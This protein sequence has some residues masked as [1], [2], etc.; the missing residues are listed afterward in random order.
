[1]GKTTLAKHLYY[2]LNS[3]IA[4]TH[5]IP[6]IITSE[7]WHRFALNTTLSLWDIWREALINANISDHRENLFEVCTKSG[8]LIPIFDG[9]DELCSLWSHQFYPLDVIK[10]LFNLIKDEDGKIL[11][12]SRDVFWEENIPSELNSQIEIFELRPFNK[13]QLT[14][15]LEMRFPNDFEARKRARNLVAEYEK[16]AYSPMDK[17]PPSDL[18]L[19]NV[20]VVIE[21]LSSCAEDSANSIVDLKRDPIYEILKMLCKRERNRHKIITNEETQINIFRDIAVEYEH[22]FRD[23][24]L[25]FWAQCNS[26]EFNSLDKL[27][28]L[29]SHPFLYRP[30]KSKNN[31]IFRYD[32]LPI[33]LRALYAAEYLFDLTKYTELNKKIFSKYPHGAQI[34]YDYLEDILTRKFENVDDL[35]Q[36]IKEFIINTSRNSQYWLDSIST[37]CFYIVIKLIT[38]F[39]ASLSKK[40]RTQY[41][42][43]C[44][45]SDSFKK[46]KFT[47][48]I[49]SLDFRNMKFEDTIFTEIIFDKCDFDGNTTFNNC[50]FLGKI[51][52]HNCEGVRKLQIPPNCYMDEEARDALYSVVDSVKIIN[53]QIEK[54]IRDFLK[55]FR[56]GIYFKSVSAEELFREIIFQKIEK[57]KF[58]KYFEQFEIIIS[59]HSAGGDINRYSVCKNARAEVSSFLE[60]GI[61][62]GRIKKVLTEMKKEFIEV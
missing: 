46:M 17:Y 3:K 39:N 60:N 55:K 30:D 9:F 53:S 27:K 59:E 24:D 47:G 35:W 45:N 49:K 58:L 52:F 32:F 41:I 13:Q 23:T 10:T 38:R 31:F 34:F 51:I 12:T 5:R 14:K 25:E 50:K 57:N 7:Q 42:L 26:E 37:I 11:L 43:K 16:I 33:Y 15:Y 22:S 4:E 36:K 48:I 61:I 19:G 54:W 8:T 18:R 2:S 20:P 29:H 44:F 56:S 21:L 62:A 28:V 6:I 40:E 1:V